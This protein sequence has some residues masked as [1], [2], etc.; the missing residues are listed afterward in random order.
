M[1]FTDPVFLFL[2]LPLAC[3]AF[4]TITPRFGYSAGFGA[5]LI[6]SLLFYY[7]WGP[8]YFCLL[9]ASITANFASACVLLITPDEKVGRRRAALALGLLYDFATLAWFKYRFMFDFFSGGQAGFS[10]VDIAIPIGI[11]FYTFQQATFLLDAYSREAS[12]VAYMGDMSSGWGKLRGYIHH[13]FFVSFFPHLVIGPIVYLHE[14]QPQVENP[15]FGRVRRRNLE[16]GFMLIA[17]GIFKKV[18]I[19]D[20]VGKLANHVFDHYAGHGPLPIQAAAVGVTA[21]SWAGAIA[22]YIQLYFDFSGYSDMALGTARML[23]IRFPFNFYSPLKSVGIVD[24]YRRWHITLTRVISR[25]LYTPLSVQGARFS[26][27]RNLSRVPARVLS[28]WIPLLVNFAIIGFWHGARATF[29]LFGVLQ[30]IWYIVETEVRSAKW[31]KAWRK[32]TSDGFRAVLGRVIFFFL[33]VP[34]F[35]LFRAPDLQAF[36][37]LLGGMFGSPDIVLHLGKVSHKLLLAGATGAAGII[38]LAGF[39]PNSIELLRNYRPGIR[40]YDTANYTPKMLRFAWRPDLKWALFGGAIFC[41][42]LYFIA[43]QPPFLYMG[44]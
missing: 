9:I 6:I 14:F 38:V 22:Y 15:T 29:L 25:F 5:L 10:V 8:F 44:F 34:C 21:I 7:A 37:S 32:R 16:V 12:V 20:N 35:A 19:A 42:T 1:L 40:T 23:G 33:M 11:S 43:R 41:A 2:L 30:G 27:R 17:M 36:F 24:F 13:A 31:W 4:Y 28:Q 26:I 18:V 39:L 3:I